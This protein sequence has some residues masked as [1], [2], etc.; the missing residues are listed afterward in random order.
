MRS[1]VLSK[2]TKSE[3]MKRVWK[4]KLGIENAAVGVEAEI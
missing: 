3:Y 4:S 2:L 1:V